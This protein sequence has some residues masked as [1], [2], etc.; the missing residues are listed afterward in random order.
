MSVWMK[1]AALHGAALFLL[2]QP[3]TLV[4]K[5]E[6]AKLWMA[7][8]RFA[9][10]AVLY[11]E[12]TRAVP[13]NPGLLMNLGMARHMA[14]QDAAAIAPLEAAVKLQPVPP[15]ALLFLGASYLRTGQ[16]AKAIAPLK[17]F[18]AIEPNHPESR[19]MLADAAS[20]VGDRA[21]A[22]IHLGKLAEWEPADPSAWYALGLAYR[23]I[24]D[25][26][27]AALPQDSGYWLGLAADTRNKR[28][29]TRARFLLYRKAIEKL[30]RQRGLHASLAGIYRDT[31]H[32]DWAQVEREREA[33]LG[34]P[35]CRSAPPTLECL[36]AVGRHALVLASPLAAPEARYWKS[37]AAAAL[38]DEAFAK[39]A[40]LP[41][42]VFSHRAQAEAHRDAGRHRDAAEAWR[43]ALALAPADSS[44]E[45]EL[46]TSLVQAK[47][48]DAAREIAERLLAA[49]PKAPE[50]N[51][52]LGD[53]L[54]NLQLPGPAIPPLQIAVA[55]DPKVLPARASLGRALMLAGRAAEA[56]PHL[57]AAL[58][59]DTDA[60]LHFQLSRAYQAAGKP[61]LGK[62]ML[63]RYQAMRSR[64]DDDRRKI[65]SES[66][67]TAPLPAAPARP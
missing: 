32:E 54:L 64:N 52:L 25:T 57:E 3:A 49:D 5:S 65:E 59:L 29:Q 30:P 34:A 24:A 12:L 39:L 44:L 42:S 9:D 11:E 60:S 8:Q 41:P 55:A 14:G 6:R 18:V 10:A 45:F 58:P 17:R 33:A 36:Y 37:R 56:I 22:A 23:E 15:P 13:G 31:G 20:A 51:Y 46:A 28:S 7:Q 61:E 21:E 38:A 2:A 26:Q 27:M 40:A 67:I 43:A 1:G 35:P 62:Q 53:L 50:L 63:A 16:A 48:Y 66:E 47:Q 4:E 19:R